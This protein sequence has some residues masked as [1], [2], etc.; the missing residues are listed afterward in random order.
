MQ[1]K[2]DC[3]QRSA[4]I[5]DLAI[6]RW[7]FS[8][9]T[10]VSRNLLIMFLEE[11]FSNLREQSIGEDIFFRRIEEA[12]F[13]EFCFEFSKRLG[14]CI[15]HRAIFDDVFRSNAQRLGK[16]VSID[17]HRRTTKLTASQILEFLRYHLVAFAA[18]D[19][20]GSH[21][22]DNLGRRG[23]ERRIAKVFAYA[24]HFVQQFLIFVFHAGFFELVGQIGEHT[25]LGLISK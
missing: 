14:L 1:E 16:E 2:D 3:A 20:E 4:V 17:S 24:R 13:L 6:F 21:G 10:F 8:L 25:A 11:F 15:F 19:I 22:A 7:G 23:N 18:H 9:G 12:F 5:F